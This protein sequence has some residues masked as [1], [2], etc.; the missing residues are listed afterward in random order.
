MM[1]K[2][3]KIFTKESEA[4]QIHAFEWTSFFKRFAMNQIDNKLTTIHQTNPLYWGKKICT[5][6]RKRG[7]TF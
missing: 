7:I 1:L 2:N 3:V 6:I 4:C 5:V